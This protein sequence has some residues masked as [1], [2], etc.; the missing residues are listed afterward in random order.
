MARWSG[1]GGIGA[2]QAQWTVG[3]R[4]GR[5]RGTIRV[6]VRLGL[7]TTKAFSTIAGWRRHGP[8]A[9][10]EAVTS[11]SM[12]VI[13]AQLG[14]TAVQY[15]LMVKAEYLRVDGDMDMVTSLSKRE[16]KDSRKRR[17]GRPSKTWLV[18]YVATRPD[19][20]RCLYG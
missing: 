14:G 8:P 2:H 12:L 10:H 16:N 6:G 17:S 4:Q 15:M 7:W 13:F 19:G 18:K 11:L 5:C 20:G 1:G 9:G 3:P